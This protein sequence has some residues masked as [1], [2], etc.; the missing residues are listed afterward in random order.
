[1]NFK[2][3]I[4][5]KTTAVFFALMAAA[6][7]VHS[8]IT[9]TFAQSGADVTVT[10]SGTFNP[11]VCGSS[12]WGGG[13]S[14]SVTP[15][16]G[17]IYFS[18]G[19]NA[20]YS[21]CEGASVTSSSPSFAFGSGITSSG[22]QH[23]GANFLFQPSSSSSWGPLWGP[24]NFTSSTSFASSFK[25]ISMT[26]SQMGLTSGTYV[27]TYTN[28]N[29]S[30]KQD[31]VTLVV[32]LINSAPTA[33]PVA[34][35]GTAQTGSTLTGSYNYTDADSDGEGTST[36]RWIKNNVNTGLVGGSP[37]GT[38]TTYTPVAGDIGSYLYFC[39][40]PVASAGS[41][42]GAEACS[43]SSAA[44]VAGPVNGGCGTAAN[45]AAAIV[46]TTNLCTA[47]TAGQ[48][49]S[50]QGQ[51]SW[52]CSGTSGGTN[53]SCTAPWASNAGTG[54]G[55]LTASGNN[56]TVSSAS[57]ATTP[58]VAPP[59]GVTFPNGILD[60]RLTSGYTGTDATVVVNYSTAVPAGAVYMKY[61]KTLANQTDHW[62][63]LDAS[64]AVF[65]QDRM[66]VTL[67]LTDGGDG[68][69][70][71]I[72]N[73]TIVDPGGPAL[74]PAPTAVPTLSEWAMIFLASLM[75]MFA[76]ARIRRQS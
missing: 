62:Y 75:G 61:G 59:A 44:V 58:T 54:S 71:L 67:T 3:T 40:T 45:T 25:V 23:T 42:T 14:S 50:S 46:P 21:S 35:G 56:W 52:T 18:S 69:H 28:T 10:S 76:F 39:V 65:S 63:Q 7:H 34:I 33:T 24:E 68:D 1:M 12:G 37:V 27:Y 17:S 6:G 22:T 19:S 4:V 20:G 2:T 8:A 48:V 55:S 41:T 36:F 32:P 60:L 74:V 70:D 49:S 43:L 38:T 47:G 66:S 51:Y 16:D 11:A 26:L 57:F 30:S 53:A 72:R 31:T 29:N 5:N 73:A 13:G 64:R 15:S 9:I